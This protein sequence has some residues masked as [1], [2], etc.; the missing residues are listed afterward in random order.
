LVLFPKEDHFESQLMKNLNQGV[1]YLFLKYYLIVK[2]L[3]HVQDLMDVIK[4]VSLMV[5]TQ[6]KRNELKLL[7][8][9]YMINL[10]KL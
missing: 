1:R 7:A 6:C 3:R 4:T 10:G 5:Q 8:P 2:N 9:W